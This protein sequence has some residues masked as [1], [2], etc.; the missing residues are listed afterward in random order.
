MPV[1]TARVW[2]LFAGNAQRN[3]GHAT[4]GRGAAF[5]KQRAQHGQTS[6]AVLSS[7]AAYA[8]RAIGGA[9]VI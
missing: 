5:A 1:G 9:N 8:K 6:G 2:A 7:S 4:S 3:C